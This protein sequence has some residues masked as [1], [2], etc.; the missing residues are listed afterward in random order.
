MLSHKPLLSI[1]IKNRRNVLVIGGHC[2]PRRQSRTI[3]YR[4]MD[5]TRRFH[6]LIS[7]LEAC[8]CIRHY[9]LCG[10]TTCP[11]PWR[12]QRTSDYLRTTGPQSPGYKSIKHLATTRVRQRY[13]TYPSPP[14]GKAISSGKDKEQP[15][16]EIVESNWSQQRH[17]TIS[18]APDNDGDRCALRPR[19]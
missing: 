9:P 3:C 17:N 19:G 8:A 7:H 12:L 11:T 15:V 1:D 13:Q 18:Q 14:H 2:V 5:P 16:F 6:R 10:P 4:V